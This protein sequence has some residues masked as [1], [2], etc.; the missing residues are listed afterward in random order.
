M[1]LGAASSP[2]SEQ[3]SLPQQALILPITDDVDR[4]SQQAFFAAAFRH[5]TV[6]STRH[7]T[8]CR[9]V[10]DIQL[11]W[12]GENAFPAVMLRKLMRTQ[13]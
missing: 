13:S 4:G 9:M 7:R 12:T 5:D 8:F 6:W 10:V 11:T 1:Q 2:L 3:C